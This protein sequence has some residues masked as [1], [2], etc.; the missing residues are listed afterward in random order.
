MNFYKRYLKRLDPTRGMRYI[1][2]VRKRCMNYADKIYRLLS[3]FSQDH[4]NYD[5]N[6]SE[7]L[8]ILGTNFVSLGYPNE[9]PE[10]FKRALLSYSERYSKLKHYTE[11]YAYWHDRTKAYKDDNLAYDFAKNPFVK[12]LSP[13]HYGYDCYVVTSHE[14]VGKLQFFGYILHLW[15]GEL[16]QSKEFGIEW[17]RLEPMTEPKDFRNLMKHIREQMVKDKKSVKEINDTTMELIKEWNRQ[18]GIDLKEENY[19]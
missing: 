9:T 12:V 10:D 17:Y 11:L 18:T 3:Q 7:I 14:L 8:R 1:E 5:D 4:P 19:D 6:I 16:L 13:L 15:N 2:T